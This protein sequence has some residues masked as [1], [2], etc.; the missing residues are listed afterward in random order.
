MLLSLNMID[1]NEVKKLAE[2]SRIEMTEEEMASFA[3]EIDSILGY[4]AQIQQVAGS[5]SDRTVPEHHNVFRA[6]DQPNVTESNTEII[7]KEFPKR[8]KDLL[9]VKKIL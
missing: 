1:T 2:L 6:D 8:E 4:V 9:K 7:A 3:K 5:V